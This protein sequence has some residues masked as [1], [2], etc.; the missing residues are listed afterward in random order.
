MKWFDWNPSVF[1]DSVSIADILNTM[2]P[3]PIGGIPSIIKVLE[4]PTSPYQ[5]CGSTDLKVHDIIHVLLGRGL[6]QQDEAFV[7]GYSM[8]NAANATALDR[9]IFLQMAT[10][11]Y[12]APFTFMEVDATV[13]NIAFDFGLAASQKNINNL[14]VEELSR[15]QIGS[16]RKKFNLQKDRLISFY[17]REVLAVGSTK[18]SK[19]ITE[20]F[21]LDT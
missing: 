14:D 19:R 7:I 16:A 21:G 11:K 4:N 12:P 9:M 13:F 18:V 15:M 10:T 5:L 17:N 20:S 3:A 6:L 8:G 1:E 2:P